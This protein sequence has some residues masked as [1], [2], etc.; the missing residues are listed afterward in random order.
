MDSHVNLQKRLSLRHF[1]GVRR[2]QWTVGTLFMTESESCNGGKKDLFCWRFW[3]HKLAFLV[4]CFQT[5]S[6]AVWSWANRTRWKWFIY[7]FLTTKIFLFNQKQHVFPAWLW[8]PCRRCLF[9]SKNKCILTSLT[10]VTRNTY[11]S[12]AESLNFGQMLRMQRQKK[13]Q[14]RLY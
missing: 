7:L 4:K 6:F 5:K 13:Q 14:T 2:G 12:P 9:N 10:Y 1:Q 11:K 3:G 8:S